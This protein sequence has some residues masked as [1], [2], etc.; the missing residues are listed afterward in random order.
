[1]ACGGLSVDNLSTVGESLTDWLGTAALWYLCW[2]LCTRDDVII[3]K[4]IRSGQAQNDKPRGRRSIQL[5][6][7]YRRIMWWR[8]VAGNSP[9]LCGGGPSCCSELTEATLRTT[10]RRQHEES[11]RQQLSTLSQVLKTRATKFDGKFILTCEVLASLLERSG[12]GS[13]SFL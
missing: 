10:V 3:I 1:M 13:T 2:L 5:Y 9:R 6:V 12:K 8:V 4:Q 11:V 7:M